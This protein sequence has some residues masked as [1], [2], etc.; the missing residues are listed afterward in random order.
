MKT[1]A[2]LVCVLALSAGRDVVPRCVQKCFTGGADNVDPVCGF[3][4]KTYI[5]E[6]FM[7]CINKVKNMIIKRSTLD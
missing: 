4:G 3:D 1:I 6:C 5:N 7:E 2:A